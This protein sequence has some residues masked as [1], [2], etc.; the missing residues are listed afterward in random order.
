MRTARYVSLA[1]SALSI[2]ALSACSATQ[3]NSMTTV[4]I[5]Y[6]PNIHALPFYLA[7][8]KGYFK[9]E[10]L[11]V[12]PV[13]FEAPNQI[14]DALLS[15]QVGIA[16]PGAAAGITAVSQSKKPGTIKIY[17][18]QGGTDTLSNESFVVK[19]GSDIKSFADLKGKKLG[20]LPGI[21]WQTIS[22]HILA[23]NGLEAGKDV[24]LVD[25]AIPLM[26][27]ALASGQ[28]DALLAIEPAPTIAVAKGIGSVAQKSP[29]IQYIANP[30]YAGVGDVTTKFMAENP[31]VTQKVLRALKKANDDVNANPDAARPYLKGYT[32]L[33][34]SLINDVPLLQYRMYDEI[35]EKDIAGL[36]AFFDIFTR[37]G[38]IDRNVDARSLIYA[39]PQ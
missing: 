34:D 26:V 33:D 35:D 29:T 37:Y 6:L 20:H 13:K 39:S 11:E 9:D 17:S 22:R 31:D 2:L 1:L 36:Q 7:L 8:E 19:T 38:V 21:Q 25:L 30:F 27:P 12:E 32:A 23:E 18:V 10:G 5:A 24:T 4:K 28:V 15:N 16:A 14:I 3:Q